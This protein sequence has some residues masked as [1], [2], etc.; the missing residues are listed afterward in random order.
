VQRATDAFASASQPSTTVRFDV[1]AGACDCHTHIFGD[2]TRFPFVPGRVYTPEPAS[3]RRCGC[4]TAR[5]GR[6]ASSSCSRA[7]TAR[8]NG[9]TLDAIK[10]LG[11]GARG[12]A[13][14]D[15][16]TSNAALDEMA[17]GGIRGIRVNLETGGVT[18][19]A[20]PGSARKRRSI[21]HQ[22]SPLALQLNNGLRVIDGIQDSSERDGPGRGSIISAAL[23]RRSVFGQPGLA[24]LGRPG[25]NGKRRT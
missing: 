6:H 20:P 11:A 25:E 12:V 7:C 5:C 22:R 17:R 4:C 21:A 13:V 15:E 18:D 2:Q 14:I 16:K 3:V 1:P 9:C 8:T 10:Q 23:S 24:V 19:P